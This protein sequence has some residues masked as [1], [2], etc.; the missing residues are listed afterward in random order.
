MKKP[1]SSTTTGN[2]TTPTETVAA[3][4]TITDR[5]W[6]L[7][8]LN[9]KPVA[10]TINGKEPFLM[11]QKSDNRY[12][13]TGGCNG[14]GGTFTL[15]GMGRIKFTQG[16]STMMACEEMEVENGLNKVLVT[17]DNFSLGKDTLSLNKARMAPLA[18]FAAVK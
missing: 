13:G 11:F 15:A 2:S 6:K 4:T 5:R 9:G 17:V 3:D 7:I 1:D 8:E 16:M 18:R 10:A 12:T 14:I